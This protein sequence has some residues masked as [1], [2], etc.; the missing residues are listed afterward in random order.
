MASPSSDTRVSRTWVSPCWQ[1]G[2]FMGQIQLYSSF[3]QD[4]STTTGARIH[5]GRPWATLE[6]VMQNLTL[7][8]TFWTN[9]YAAYTGCASASTF[10]AAFTRSMVAASCGLS[11]T[12]AIRLPTSSA[13]ASLKPRVVIAGLP[14]RIPEVTNGCSGSLPLP[15]RSDSSDADPPA[16]R[17]T[18]YDRT[19]YADHV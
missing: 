14:R 10:T 12:S 11:S 4:V 2:H 18:R 16:S 15:C 9:N 3:I 7:Y 8:D 1:N 13:C 17:A 5:S 19:R 6:C